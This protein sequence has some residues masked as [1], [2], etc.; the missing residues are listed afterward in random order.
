[1]SG[2]D[3]TAELLYHVEFAALMAYVALWQT[4]AWLAILVCAPLGVALRGSFD[5]RR[6]LLLGMT[7][8]TV[9]LALNPALIGLGLADD[10][11]MFRS[12]WPP[13]FFP[14][15]VMAC[16][17]LHLP[18]GLL[19]L[20]LGIAVGELVTRAS[21]ASRTAVA[22]SRPRRPDDVERWPSS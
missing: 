2:A 12:T 14:L 11:D 19:A 8:V 3:P 6:A 10:P 16:W 20:G 1:M 22:G 5:R 13:Y 17:L 18:I 15:V 9:I 7:L 21:S 4:W